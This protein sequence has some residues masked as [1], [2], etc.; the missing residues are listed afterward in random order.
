MQVV[1]TRETPLASRYT[2]FVTT[3]L[4]GILKSLMHRQ[5][6]EII[7]KNIRSMK[8]AHLIETT[9]KKPEYDALRGFSRSIMNKSGNILC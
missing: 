7:L 3:K 1:R 5:M 6:I 4:Q 9:A 8:R 2:R